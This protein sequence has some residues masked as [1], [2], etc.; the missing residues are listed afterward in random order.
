MH[1][2]YKIA[3]FENIRPTFMYRTSKKDC[4]EHVYVATRMIATD[5]DGE[6]HRT[7]GNVRVTNYQPCEIQ[8]IASEHYSLLLHNLEETGTAVSLT[9]G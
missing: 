6:L 8:V 3:D 5:P 4:P 9:S 1:N 7:F 2:T